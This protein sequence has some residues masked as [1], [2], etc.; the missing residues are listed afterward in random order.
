MFRRYSELIKLP[1]FEERFEYL[2][3]RG[4]IGEETFGPERYL[5]QQL[6]SSNIWR[7]TKQKV[8]IRDNAFDLGIK[9]Y[10][11]FGK[12]VVHHINPIT[13]DDVINRNPIIF[14]LENLIC[15]SDAT[16]RAIH[17]GDRK[18]LPRVVLSRQPNDTTPWKK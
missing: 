18:L 9:D 8:I 14:N 10:E 16:H 7:S 12:I 2:K 13:I 15:V 1:T 11:I 3:L 5:N 17:Y 4:K 6:Y